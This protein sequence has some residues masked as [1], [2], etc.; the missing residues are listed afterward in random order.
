MQGNEVSLTIQ[1]THKDFVDKFVKLEDL[2]VNDISVFPISGV[3]VN[4]VMRRNKKVSSPKYVY[5]AETSG[6]VT[7][8]AT[9][10]SLECSL[11]NAEFS[12]RKIKL[13]GKI[14]S[15]ELGVKSDGETVEIVEYEEEPETWKRGYPEEAFPGVITVSKDEEHTYCWGTLYA[16]RKALNRLANVLSG[17]SKGDTIILEISVIGLELPIKPGEQKNFNVTGYTPTLVKSYS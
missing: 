7:V 10:A 13:S 8:V 9:E 11:W 16:T 12:V 5:N 15:R 6:S 14:N 3:G 17:M 4:R 1:I 2:L